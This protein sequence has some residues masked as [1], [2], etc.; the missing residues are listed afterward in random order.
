[1]SFKKKY[2]GHYCKVCGHIRPNEKF[3]VKGHKNHIFKICSKIP[4]SQQAENCVIN[5]LYRLYKYPSLSRNNKN[6]LKKHLNDSRENIKKAAIEI[7]ESFTRC[8]IEYEENTEYYLYYTDEQNL[9]KEN[10]SVEEIPF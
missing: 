6:L 9:R 10:I 8:P 3:S 5:N 7:W 4:I 1:M 2:R